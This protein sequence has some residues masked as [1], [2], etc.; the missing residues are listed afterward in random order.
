M[1]SRAQQAIRLSEEDLYVIIFEIGVALRY[2]WAPPGAKF[3]AP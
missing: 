1:A 3:R 2:E